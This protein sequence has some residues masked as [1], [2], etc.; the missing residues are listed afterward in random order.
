M[1]SFDHIPYLPTNRKEMEEF[2]WD[3]LDV[4]LL[5]GDAY[6]DHP[7]FGVPLIG[8]I[9]L[10]AGFRTGIIAQFPWQDPEVLKVMGTPRIGIGISSGNLDSM[11]NIYTAGRRKRR[12]DAYIENGETGKRPPH[13]LV[14]Y[15][16][17][18]KR[19]F[20][21]VPVVLGGLEASMR[22]VTHYDYWQ[23]KLRFPVLVDTKADILIYGMGERP[24]LEIFNRLRDH[25]SLEGIPGTARL[26]GKKA[27]ECFVKPDNFYELPSHEEHLQR[28][29]ALMDAI[30]LVEL[31][32]NQY[33]NRGLIE[34]VGDRLLVVEP[35]QPPLTSEELDRVNELNF[36][37][38]PHPMHK[39]RIPAFETIRD[40]I[41]AIRGCPG[42]CTFCGLVAHQG[43]GVTS[44]SEQSILRDVKRLT[45]SKDFKGTISDI[46]GAAG[47]IYGSVVKD[48]NKCAQ[49]RRS[50]CLWP[51][52]CPNFSCDGKR[53]IALL[54]EV[55]NTPGVKHLYINS[56]MRL[57]LANMQK[58]LFREIIRYHVSGH[59]KVAP[60]HLNDDV[61]KLMRKNPAQDFYVFKKFFEEESK[62]AGKEQYLIPLF[63]SNFPGCTAE[64]MK[65]V[66][67]YLDA[68]N[69]SPQ[70][71][72]DYIP[73]PMTMGGAMYYTGLAPD[74][75]PIEV[76]RG[77]AER[78]T[79]INMLK[80]KRPGARPRQN[81]GNFQS[82]PENCKSKGKPPYSGKS[83]KYKGKPRS[84]SR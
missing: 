5:T 39:N 64:K 37:R 50:S 28:K 6:V 23:D 17:L 8:R 20:P 48:L 65:T 16:Q 83:G 46:G 15:S 52:P 78:R 1:T 70:Q 18:A 76:N 36:S 71:V 57:D 24:I 45:A 21:G 30:K 10:A 11:V 53:L 79:Q 66:D 29:S 56:G 63:I 22:R 34:K 31:A 2:G 62:S 54:R 4:L 27:A 42:G 82:N 19:A 61:L 59:M 7:S 60:E 40:S 3:A 14:V 80:K 73:L 81:E 38:K 72:Q 69:W 41:P 25:K 58:D 74:G 43:R 77:L 9:L 32:S 49:C 55:R 44:R 68:H 51:L 75:T 67:D 13:A 35:P 47:N 26:L 84:G 33:A 12:E